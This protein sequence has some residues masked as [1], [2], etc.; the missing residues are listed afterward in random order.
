MLQCRRFY[1]DKNF[2][3]RIIT[4][5]YNLRNLKWSTKNNETEQKNNLDIP[6]RNNIDINN[7]KVLKSSNSTNKNTIN[8]EDEEEKIMEIIKQK[9]EISFRARKRI[10]S[11]LKISKDLTEELEECNKKENYEEKDSINNYK[12]YK[13]I[14]SN[15]NFE[16]KNDSRNIYKENKINLKNSAN[17]SINNGTGYRNRKFEI[18]NTKNNNIEKSYNS[19]VDNGRPKPNLL[20]YRNVRHIY[21]KNVIKTLVLKDKNT[22][23]LKLSEINEKANNNINNN[24]YIINK[25]GRTFNNEDINKK[26]EE[27]KFPLQEI[28][29]FNGNDNSNN[30]NFNLRNRTETNLNE[31]YVQKFTRINSDFIENKIKKIKDKQN[32]TNN[33]INSNNNFENNNN[34]GNE[35]IKLKRIKTIKNNET[36]NKRYSYYNYLITKGKRKN[37]IDSEN[38]NNKYSNMSFKLETNIHRTYVKNRFN[39]NSHMIN[40]KALPNNKKF[41]S[42]ETE[43]IDILNKGILDKKNF[44]ITFFEC[45]INICDSINNRNLFINLIHNFNLKYFFLN[46][47]NYN[48]EYST[49]FK[50]NENFEYV[51]KHFGLVIISL[52]F[53]SK[54]DNLY[55]IYNNK[56]KELLIQIIYSSLNYVEMNNCVES[57]IIYNFNRVNDFQ[58]NISIH[59]YVLSLINLLFDNKRE[60]L[61][62]K[63]ALD[64]MHL[65]LM[66]KDFNYILKIINESILFCHNSKQRSTYTFP[67][68]K[69]NN[70]IISLK[71]TKD[72]SNYNNYNTKTN[73]NSNS[74]DNEKVDSIPFIK[75]PMK[76]KFCLVLDIDETISHTLKLSYGGYFLLRPGAKSFLEEVSKYYEII[77]FTSSP[78]KYA[79][80]ILD[81]IDVNGNFF[82][83]RLYK[84][85]VLYENGKT[86][87]NLNLIGRDLLKT[88]FI[89][90]L[91]SNAKYNLDN[92][93]PITTWKSDIFDTRLIKL[94]DKL[95]YI[96]NCG[97]YDDDITQGLNI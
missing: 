38:N 32:E 95:C 37:G 50:D 79:D 23:D 17:N 24:N 31:K 51:I 90:N 2:K 21:K 12:K 62:L 75:S 6:K 39:N 16:L 55:N 56:V 15:N 65:I 34:N 48:D 70:N 92:L 19:N 3:N 9:N 82:S 11:R 81:K 91:R 93:C 28:K 13:R 40:L 58:L 52:I 85:H 49:I 20:L 63:E 74:I 8:K 7:L 67:F 86:V 53:L 96:A 73:S 76:K 89:D 10:I 33:I 30:N 68:F 14:N 43:K 64:Q 80:K 61:P 84:N 25:K 26:N 94:K 59:R 22:I 45:A 72:N 77:I 83:H 88:I 5:S 35:N 69:F 44:A 36:G 66:K 4:H 54:D 71:I 97:K 18:Y 47:N 29:I 57:D 60:Y 1:T 78:K 27:S 87:K 46:N 41:K 42:I